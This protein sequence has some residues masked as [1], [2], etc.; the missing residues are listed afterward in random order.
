MVFIPNTV[1]EIEEKAFADNYISS[2]EFEEGFKLS[3]ISMGT[4]EKNNI[5]EVELPDSVTVIRDSAFSDN[6]IENLVLGP[7]VKA[8]ESSAFYGNKI[9]KVVLP[10]GIEEVG[11]TSFRDNDLEIIVIP[12]SLKLINRDAF[13]DGAEVGVVYANE[14][15]YGD[16]EQHYDKWP[17]IRLHKFGP[18]WELKPLSEYVE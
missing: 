6:D 18:G 8:I 15:D 1:V 16:Y 7:D 11:N 14:M 12:D 9:K 13:S 2:L 17:Q 5:E 10:H 3:E 4:F